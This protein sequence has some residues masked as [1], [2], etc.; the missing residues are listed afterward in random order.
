M[1]E[2]N[3]ARDMIE[4]LAVVVENDG[5]AG[6]VGLEE[7]APADDGARVCVL[8]LANGGRLLVTVASLPAE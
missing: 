3:V 6:V 4:A 5:L 2:V 8:H 1:V 7:Q